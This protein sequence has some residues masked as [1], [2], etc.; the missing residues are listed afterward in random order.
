MS[1][2]ESSESQ[3]VTEK[4][5]R[6]T[7]LEILLQEKFNAVFTI[8]RERYILAKY[9]LGCFGQSNKLRICC[10]HM[11]ANR[12]FDRFI[13][14]C[15]LLNS[16]MLATK[17][18]EVNYNEKS[19]SRWNQIIDT[20]DIVFS[21]IYLVECL[22]KIVAL[23]FIRHKS[24]YLRDGWNWIDFI[25]VCLSGTLLIPATEST[26]YK[27]FRTARILRPLRSLHQLRSMKSLIQTIFA[28]IPGL[29]NVCVFQTFIFSLF[30]IISINFFVGK[31]Y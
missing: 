24:A 8:G 25:I 23:G 30:A 6:L 14:L 15:I 7:E 13:T 5:E 19:V 18:Y 2:G 3:E 4:E 12:W 17:Q 9:S 26:N 22:I 16:V 21:V 29:F 10:V 11:I 31:Q 28:S 20:A 1:R 27:A